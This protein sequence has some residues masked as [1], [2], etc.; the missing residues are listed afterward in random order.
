MGS[1]M[2]NRL[3]EKGHTGCRPLNPSG[4]HTPISFNDL[5][6]ISEF[7]GRP[8]WLSGAGSSRL[9]CPM[10]LDCEAFFLARNLYGPKRKPPAHRSSRAR[11]A[12]R[13]FDRGGQ[14]DDRKPIVSDCPNHLQELIEID[15]LDDIRTAAEFVHLES[16]S[17]LRGSGQDDDWQMT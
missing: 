7:Q 17:V 4:I 14:D 6:V 10:R 11:M 12:L 16:L 8:F 3:L 5:H 2:V 13:S 1:Q 9:P 15:W